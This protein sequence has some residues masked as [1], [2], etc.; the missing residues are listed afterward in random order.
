[1][2]THSRAIEV[3]NTNPVAVMSFETLLQT[4]RRH[5]GELQPIATI[6]SLL[7]LINDLIMRPAVPHSALHPDEGFFVCPCRGGKVVQK[8]VQYKQ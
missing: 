3:E 2:I 4:D 5:L 8:L 1:M 7:F 6:G